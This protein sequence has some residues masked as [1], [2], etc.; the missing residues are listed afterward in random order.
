LLERAELL[1]LGGFGAEAVFDDGAVFGEEDVVVGI[2]SWVAVDGSDG[3][4]FH[5]YGVAEFPDGVAEGIGIAGACM[6][7]VWWFSKER[8]CTRGRMLAGWWTDELRKAKRLLYQCMVGTGCGE[9]R[10]GELVMVGYTSKEWWANV[11]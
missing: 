4:L 8:L 2:V 9:E 5:G 1:A 10:R 3:F 7:E 6:R 11:V